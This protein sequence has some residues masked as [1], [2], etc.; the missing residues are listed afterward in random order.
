MRFTFNKLLTYE[1]QNKTI[2]NTIKPYLLR[3][4]VSQKKE[5]KILI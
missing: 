4:Y 1:K 2:V 3:K 5:K